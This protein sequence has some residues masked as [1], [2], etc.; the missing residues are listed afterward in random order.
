MEKAELEGV[1]LVRARCPHCYSGRIRIDWPA[2]KKLRRLPASMMPGT[3]FYPKM[4][5]WMRC[6]ECGGG[7]LA[8]SDGEEAGHWEPFPERSTSGARTDSP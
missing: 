8:S 6:H 1:R 3:S 4:D 2:I 7:F 5:I